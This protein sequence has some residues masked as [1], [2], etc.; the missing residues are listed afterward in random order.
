VW[1]WGCHVWVGW[2]RCAYVLESQ[3]EILVVLLS[4]D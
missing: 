2:V 4:C 3:I 1:R